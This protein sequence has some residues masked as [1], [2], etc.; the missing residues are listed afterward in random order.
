M[1]LLFQAN[2]IPDPESIIFRGDTTTEESR[3]WKELAEYT[4]FYRHLGEACGLFSVG[5]LVSHM[6]GV[7]H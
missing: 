4:D 2:N 3:H 1:F 7:Q 5:S 6:Q